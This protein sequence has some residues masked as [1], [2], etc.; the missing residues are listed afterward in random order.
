MMW[1]QAQEAPLSRQ[2]SR[3]RINKSPGLDCAR[4]GG[5]VALAWR[6]DAA[7]K[8]G[9]VAG[10]MSVLAVLARDGRFRRYL[11]VSY[12]NCERIPA[13]YVFFVGVS[14]EMVQGDLS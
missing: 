6:G 14:V 1:R 7:E 8:N 9:D 2:R 10:M 3:W 13:T 5:D 12:E 4:R 11:Q